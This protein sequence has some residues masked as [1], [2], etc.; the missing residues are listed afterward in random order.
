M[1]SADPAATARA[2][3]PE[4]YGRPSRVGRVALVLA[5]GSLV[6]AG[7]GWLVVSALESSS[8]DVDAG[9]SAFDVVSDRRTDLTLEVR[10]SVDTAVRCDVYAQ[11]ADKQVVG[12]RAVELAGG[13]AGTELVTVSIV[14]ERRAV[15]A[16]VRGCTALGD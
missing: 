7:A 1:H 10:R 6:A 12:E 13:P 5:I 15:A 14:T 4:R 16:A 11:A 3:M 9:V 2:A 8:P